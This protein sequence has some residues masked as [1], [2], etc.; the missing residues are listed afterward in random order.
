MTKI[1]QLKLIRTFEKEKGI[2]GNVRREKRIEPYR[3]TMELDCGEGR[4]FTIHV[5]LGQYINR[6]KMCKRL[7]ANKS[8]V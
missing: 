1:T 2:T 7:L 8:N 3:T 4:S 5:S 6:K